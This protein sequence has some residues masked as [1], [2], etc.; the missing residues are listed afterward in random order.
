MT[1]TIS[2]VYKVRVLLDPLVCILG[3]LD[4]EIF[5]P[6]GNIAIHRLLYL[7]RKQIA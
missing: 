3:A 6:P 2:K 7:A 4:N 1:E 5:A